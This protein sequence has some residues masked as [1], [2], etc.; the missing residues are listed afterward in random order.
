MLLFE[1]AQ[2]G[3][4]VRKGLWRW[5]HSA[6]PATISFIVAVATVVAI[7]AP[8][9][10]V[11]IVTISLGPR[12][13]LNHHMIAHPLMVVMMMVVVVVG[14]VVVTGH[15]RA[16]GAMLQVRHTH[17]GHHGALHAILDDLLLLDLLEDQPGHPARPA[18]RT[19]AVPREQVAHA[20][21]RLARQGRRVRR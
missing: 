21:R 15:H 3:H 14:V 13:L 16:A 5:G 19:A 8:I 4:V 7:G 9:G 11:S 17:V 20:A 18:L 1:L 6:A 2:I 10:L 12:M